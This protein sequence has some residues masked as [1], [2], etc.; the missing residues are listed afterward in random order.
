MM[1]TRLEAGLIA[2]ILL[3]ILV[4]PPLAGQQVVIRG[5]HVFDGVRDRTV[6]NSGIVIQSGKFLE[7]DAR[8]EGRDLRDVEVVELSDDDYVIPG[9]FDLHAHY[10]MDLFGEG[11]VDERKGYPSLFS[12]TV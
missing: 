8:L 4:Q 7:V 9:M 5:G 10:A 11:R 1:I 2:A 6:P 12:P 3:S